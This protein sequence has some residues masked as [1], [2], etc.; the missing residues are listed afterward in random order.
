[1]GRTLHTR[2]ESRNDI[3]VFRASELQRTARRQHLVEHL[4]LAGPRPVLEALLSVW[5]GQHL[6]VVLE[7]FGR[8]PVS[9][10]LAVG[11]DELPIHRP[12]GVIDGG[13]HD[14]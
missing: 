13:R 10:Y 1:M 4:H 2:A 11:A 6:D 3:D 5:N 7:D 9:T 12:L 14:A 8:I